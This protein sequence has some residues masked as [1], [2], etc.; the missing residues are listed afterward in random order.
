[1]SNIKKAFEQGKAFVAFITCGDPDLETT[2]AAVR[3]AV[4]NGA[5][6]IE[7][8]IPFSDPTAEGPVIQGANIRALSGGVTTDKIFDL[9]RD[10]RTDITVPMVFMTYANVVF[11]YGAETF[12]ATCK[13]IGI[14]GLILPDIPYE[15]KEEF[16]PICHKYDVELI[17]LIAPTSENRIS[18]IAKEAEGFLYIVSS[19]GVTGT[20]SEIKTDLK[21]IVD[22][23]RQNTNIPCAIGFG[24][25]TPEQAG[26]MA[27]ISDGAI[28]GS[29]I[30][31]LIEQYGKE[32]PK[33]VGEY[34]KAMK[35][36]TIGEA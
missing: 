4:A 20:R 29:A 16:L 27:A 24:I 21:T 5:D 19:L 35:K 10:L 11:S 31:K 6:L 12:I 32:S 30:V 3:A 14:D 15:E 2:A 33:Y 36:G 1:M 25:S 26:K 9:V 22:V 28:V 17:S 23:V 8:G 13:E 34:V 18:M 7:L